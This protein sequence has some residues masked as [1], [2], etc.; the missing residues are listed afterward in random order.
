MEGRVRLE[1]DVG[2]ARRASSAWSPDVRQH[3]GRTLVRGGR[4]GRLGGMLREGECA[5]C[6]QDRERSE[7]ALNFS[8][9]RLSSQTEQAAKLN[10]QWN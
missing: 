9:L 10:L 6:K 2:L 7:A 5:G 1:D 4:G 3:G 8:A